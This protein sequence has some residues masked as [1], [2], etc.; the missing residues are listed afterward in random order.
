[1]SA[2]AAARR[3][4]SPSATRAAA[5]T[6]RRRSRSRP[7]FAIDGPAIVGVHGPER[8][9]QDDA[10]RAHHRQQPAERGPRAG[11]RARTS[12]RVRYA[13]ARPAGDP[14]P[15]VLP[16]ARVPADAGPT[17]MLE[18]AR[19]E[20]AAGASLRRAAVQPAGRLH[21]LHARLLPAPARPRA[22]WSSCACIRTSRTT[23]RSC[24]RAASASS[25]SS[26]ARLSHAPS[27]PAL[28]ADE[29]VRAYLGR[30]AE[31]ATA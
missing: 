11:R 12:T 31:A 29:R 1:M 8:L 7:T 25:S 19:R 9:R 26:A 30:L 15:P 5:S 16:G 3:A 20:R 13:R 18:R 21:R 23:S 22:S 28:T 2:S 14:L 10:V 24:A 6:A 17:F 27:W 4:A